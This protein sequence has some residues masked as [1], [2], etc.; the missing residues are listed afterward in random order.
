MSEVISTT[1]KNVWNGWIEKNSRY[2]PFPQSWEW[3]DVLIAEG[4]KVERLMVKENDLI[5]GYAQ[6]VY[7]FLPLGIKY[8]FC[9]KGPILADIGQEEVVY[10][11]LKNYLVSKNCVFL[12]VEPLKLNASGKKVIDTNPRATI[13]LDLFLGEEKLLENM[14]QKT[15]YNIRLADKKNLVISEKK[16]LNEFLKLEKK[17]GERDKFKLH[18]E[19]HYHEVLNSDLSYQISASLNAKIIAANIFVGFGNTFTYLYGASDYEYRNSMAPY[20]I[21]W[22][23]IKLGRKLGYHYYDFFGIAPKQGTGEVYD[24]E[25]THQYAGVTRFKLGFG[26]SIKEDPGTF[27][28]VYS[29]SKYMAYQ[30]VRKIRRWV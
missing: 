3:G 17:T 8:A 6:I 11:A 9:P 12:R 13:I 28:L 30:I 5:F 21:Q 24:Y 27:D 16:D 10:Q 7:N 22:E 15:R 4:K 18:N 23:G 26:G 20:L 19:K 1:E 2:S 25:P 29:S 14:H